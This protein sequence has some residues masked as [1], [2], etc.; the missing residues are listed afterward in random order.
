MPMPVASLVEKKGFEDAL[1]NLRWN[2]AA[3]VR[4]GDAHPEN[5]VRMSVPNTDAESAAVWRGVQRVA[6]E[7]GE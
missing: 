1:L 6:D 4:H 5:A 3:G 7:I 2:A